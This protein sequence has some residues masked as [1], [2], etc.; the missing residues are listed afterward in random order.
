MADWMTSEMGPFQNYSRDVGMNILVT[1]TTGY[2]GGLLVPRL[3]DEGYSVTC[4]VR[5]ATRL[6]RK[7]ER[8]IYHIGNVL[9]YET[10]PPIMK[11]IDAAYYLIHSMAEGEKGFEERDYRAAE[12]FGKAARA[13]G[14]KRII[15]LGGLGEKDAKLSSHLAS[16]Q[17]VGDILRASGVPV[18]EFQAGVVIGSGSMSFEMIRYLTERVPVMITP[19]WVTTRCQPISIINVLEYL[20]RSLSEPRSVGRTFEIGGPEVMIYGDMM[21]KYA[22]ARQ[23]KRLLIRVPV[24]T[25]RLSSYWVDLV[26]PIPASYSHPL[27]EGLRSEVIL[28]DTSAQDIFWLDLIPFDEAVRQALDISGS[29]VLA[30]YWDGTRP[31]PKQAMSIKIVE[32]MIIEE[33][34]KVLEAAPGTIFQ[35]LEESGGENGWH[36]A[37]WIWELRA[38]VDRWFGGIGMRRGRP[39]VEKLIPGSTVDFWQVEALKRD[40]LLRLRSELKTPGPAWLQFEMRPQ[41]AGGTL[42]IQ[43]SLFQPHGLLGVLYWYALYPIHRIVFSGMLKAITRRANQTPNG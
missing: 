21:R 36:Y 43:A 16:R 9:E 22:Q 40:R 29:T 25:P 31:D 3:I 6:E 20:E 41:A 33:R 2:I 23:L 13:A 18:T 4:L 38:L 15:Y 24:L 10:L 8:A 17:K 32:G 7:W 12:N 1:G 39:A 35:I 11:G 26:T 27:I 14:V 19:R 5:D 30:G 42:L 37:N 34:C 28:H